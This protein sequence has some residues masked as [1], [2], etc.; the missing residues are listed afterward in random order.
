MAH[1]DTFYLCPVLPEALAGFFLCV[2]FFFNLINNM[3]FFGLF[4][5]NQM[6]FEIEFNDIIKWLYHIEPGSQRDP[7]FSLVPRSVLSEGS[8]GHEQSCP[9]YSS[10]FFEKAQCPSERNPKTFLWEEALQLCDLELK[11]ILGRCISLGQ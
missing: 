5:F 3:V 8:G 10:R 7:C 4:F 6:Q 1:T 2:Y 11:S 9:L